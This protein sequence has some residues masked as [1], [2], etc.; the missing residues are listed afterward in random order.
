MDLKPFVCSSARD[1]AS[2][3]L[4][5]VRSG[6][7]AFLTQCTDLCHLVLFLQSAS[8][9]LLLKFFSREATWLPYGSLSTF[10]FLFLIRMIWDMDLEYFIFKLYAL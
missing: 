9:Y 8:V 10:L 3:P 2:V 4:T 5:W 1:C 7:L 6:L